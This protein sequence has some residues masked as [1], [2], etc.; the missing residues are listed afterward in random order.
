MKFFVEAPVFAKLPSVCFG[1]VVARGV[2]NGGAHPEIARLLAAAVSKVREKTAACKAKELPEIRP[3]REAF[4][5]LGINSN[6]FPSSIEALAARIEKKREFP[7]INPVVD[8]GN[9]ISLQYLVPLGAHDLDSAAGDVCVRLSQPGDRFVPFG[10]EQAEELPPGELIYAVGD[11]VKTRRWIWRQSEIGK[12]TEHSSNIFF[13]VDGFADQNRARVI[14]AR[15][16]LA[17]CL[18]EC[19]HCTV[20]VGYVDKDCR[21]MVL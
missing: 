10:E 12:V 8:L 13:P 16:E 4:A 6:K 21:E 2:T 3:Y 19:F 1:V 20:T 5:A 7:R 15:D 9:A 14:A 18:Q 17:R 11:G